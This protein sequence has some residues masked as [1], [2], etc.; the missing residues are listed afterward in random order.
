MIKPELVCNVYSFCI[1]RAKNITNKIRNSIINKT[2]V[3]SP[4]DEDLD[5]I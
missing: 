4:R 3:N 2:N 5:L 1:T